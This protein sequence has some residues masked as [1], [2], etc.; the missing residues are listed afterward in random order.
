LDFAA[1]IFE[2]TKDR[3]RNSTE[4]KVARRYLGNLKDLSSLIE[5]HQNQ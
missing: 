1:R 4:A 2:H 5:A 3:R